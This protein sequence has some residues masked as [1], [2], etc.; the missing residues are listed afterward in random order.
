MQ[1][2]TKKI[3]NCPHCSNKVPMELINSFNGKKEK[4]YAKNTI[5]LI[6]ASISGNFDENVPE[7]AHLFFDEKFIVYKCPTC[8]KISI[9]RISVDLLSVN[10][11][12][13]LNIDEITELIYPNFKLLNPN[14]VPQ[15]ICEM[16]K[17]TNPLKNISPNSYGIQIRKIL[18]YLCDENGAAENANIY[19]KLESLSNRGVFP[20]NIIEMGHVIR[21]VS[22][23]GGHPKDEDITAS[24]ADLLD[25]I[26]HLIIDYVYIT[27]Y[28]IKQLEKKFEKVNKQ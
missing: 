9:Y 1:L 10:K 8:E 23:Y 20:K 16:Y 17:E 4:Y 22:R 15:K 12:E 25:D 27:P 21:K 14:I 6:K 13:N 7:Y 18:E 3:F 19:N 11:V 24:D 2:D 5:E 28:K 26:F